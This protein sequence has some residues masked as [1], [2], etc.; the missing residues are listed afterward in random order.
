MSSEKYPSQDAIINDIV[1][2]RIFEHRIIVAGSRGFDD[3]EYFSIVITELLKNKKG[4]VVFYSGMCPTGADALIVRFCKDN[5][6]L[7]WP[8]PADWDRFGKG[9][10]FIR[11]DLMA[12]TATELVAFHD[13]VS[14]GTTHMIKKAKERSLRLK[15]IDISKLKVKQPTVKL[16]TIQ[17]PKWR[18]AGA[19]G[20]KFIDTTAKSGV[21]AFAPDM[22]N[23]LAYKNKTLSEEEYTR[24]YKDKLYNSRNQYPKVWNHLKD[25]NSMAF[26]CYCP[27]GDFCHRHIFIEEVKLFLD[28]NNVESVIVGEITNEYV[29]SVINSVI[30][31]AVNH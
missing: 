27:P 26:G 6:K 4:S 17:V 2:Y 30:D 19:I 16:F 12:T 9:A 11:N 14:P 29:D 10:G 7:Y 23:V 22:E 5:K 31:D 1:D 15:V 13:G 8:Y 21:K 24:R 25:F 28:S 18:L 3:Y 20:V